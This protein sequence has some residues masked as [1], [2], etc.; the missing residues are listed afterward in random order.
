[1]TETNGRFR[2]QMIRLVDLPGV[3]VIK[4]LQDL[5]HDVIPVGGEASRYFGPSPYD[6]WF[7]FGVGM[8]GRLRGVQYGFR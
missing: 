6:E 8:V 1:M 4:G 3:L 2:H 7:M 5:T